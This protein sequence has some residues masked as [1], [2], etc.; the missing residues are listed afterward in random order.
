VTTGFDDIRVLQA[1]ETVAD[2]LWK[3]VLTWEKFAKDVVGNQLTRAAD[4]IG[5]NIAESYGRYHFGDK[6][7]FLYYARGSLFETKYWLNRSLARNLITQKQL[8]KFAQTVTSIGR[9]LNAFTNNLKSQ[10]NDNRKVL[11]ESSPEYFVD[12]EFT[13]PLFSSSDLDWLISTQNGDEKSPISNLQS[14]I[15]SGNHP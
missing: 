14:P 5:A 9:Q 2:D 11:K 12:A 7:N 8:D 1:A 6:I 3:L 10:R 13:L 4:S 15:S